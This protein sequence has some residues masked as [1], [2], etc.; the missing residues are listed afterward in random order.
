MKG[1]MAGGHIFFMA[2]EVLLKLEKLLIFRVG[3][4]GQSQ[5]GRG[6]HLSMM[7]ALKSLCRET[8][9]HRPA[10]STSGRQILMLEESLNWTVALA[11][12]S[13]SSSSFFFSNNN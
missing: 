10:F 8:R 1:A 2:L 7:L 5:I 9:V 12:A 4:I 6:K 11:A 13:S 3:S